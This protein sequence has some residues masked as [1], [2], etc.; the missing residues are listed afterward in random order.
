MKQYSRLHFRTR[1]YECGII[2][3]S[4]LADSYILCLV[5]LA[6]QDMVFKNLIILLDLFS[7]VV[8]LLH[9]KIN[10]V[11]APGYSFLKI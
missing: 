4:D 11:Q 10:V 2:F 9:F 3:A 8:Y 1:S 6:L 7:I 5:V